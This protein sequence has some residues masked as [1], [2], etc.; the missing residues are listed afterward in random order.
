[1]Y[2]PAV[3]RF[4]SEDPLPPDGEP[5]LLGASK[6]QFDPNKYRYAEN[7]PVNCVDPS[8]LWSE[9][10]TIKAYERLYGDN[11]KAMFALFIVLSFYELEHGDFWA[12]DYAPPDS[13]KGVIQIAKTAWA[14][15]ERTDDNAAE[16]LYEILW[17]YFPDF[18]L[19]RTWSRFAYDLPVGATK[20]GLGI[21]GALGFGAGSAVDPDPTLLTRIGLAGAAVVSAD[22]AVEGVTQVTGHGGAGG[23]SLIQEAAG[24]YGRTVA[25][26]EGEI[27]ARRA[28]GVSQFALG[29]VSGLRAAKSRVAFS[30][31][32]V[33]NFRGSLD[34]LKQAGITD[35]TRIRTAS[36]ELQEAFQR[37]RAR[38]LDTVKTKKFQWT[39]PKIESGI[40]QAALR[41]L[42]L[43]EK[44]K[45]DML[46]GRYEFTDPKG[47]VG[48]WRDAAGNYFLGEGHH[49]MNAALEIFEET[50]NASYVNELLK[51][52]LWELQPPPMP[53]PLPRK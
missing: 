42:E 41:D 25:G 46:N 49:R 22:F 34:D 36:R 27:S 2:Q 39:G 14:G 47:I 53:G 50:G 9:E 43:V 35:I 8:G 3:A 6:N 37:F 11:D 10:A 48:G 45:D 29:L 5:L 13:E 18:D 33:K 19:P 15:K 32:N 4:K 12:D 7:N 1:M 17:R 44:I 20:A 52:G 23:I 51:H 40:R 24:W 21:V 30:K 16:Q 26:A 38:V 31:I 28:I